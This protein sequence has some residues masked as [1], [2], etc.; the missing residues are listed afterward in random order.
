M[1]DERRRE[2]FNQ[3][4]EH[5]CPPF[6]EAT[7]R[8]N[9]GLLMAQRMDFLSEM[10]DGI[11]RGLSGDHVTNRP[12]G[13]SKRMIV[14]CCYTEFG[15]SGRK[16]GLIQDLRAV[17]AKFMSR[18]HPR[19][20][21]TSAAMRYFRR[22]TGEWHLMD[23][24]AFKVRVYKK[25]T[26]HIEVHPQI[27]WRLNQIL[28]HRHPSAIPPAHRQRP[29]RAPKSVTLFERPI[30]FAVLEALSA[31]TFYAQRTN[32]H[33]RNTFSLSFSS[34]QDSHVK[35]ALSEIL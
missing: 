19:Y 4:H 29:K 2:W 34:T 33:E 6:D 5:E 7:V 8:D 22:F 24:G 35:K 15:T 16:Q 3:I 13:F 32:I 17:V 12:E 25:G 14:D 26:A 21:A 10:V 31:G 28:A 20:G 23:G 30:P 11:F 1:P 27:A 9:I 18:D